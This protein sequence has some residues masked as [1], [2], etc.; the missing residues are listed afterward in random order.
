MEDLG[1][2]CF[3]R[4][5]TVRCLHELM[6]TNKISGFLA[7]KEQLMIKREPGLTLDEVDI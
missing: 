4:K 7:V 3:L 2:G 1:G 6:E 5:L